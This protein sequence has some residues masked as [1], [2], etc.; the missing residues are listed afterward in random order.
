ME[1]EGLGQASDLQGAV[2]LNILYLPIHKHLTYVNLY[3]EDDEFIPMPI[4]PVAAAAPVHGMV[5]IE[6]KVSNTSLLC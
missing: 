3:S 1:T 4:T 2:L 5:D 6:G